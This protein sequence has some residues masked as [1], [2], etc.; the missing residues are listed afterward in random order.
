VSHAPVRVS[1]P[2]PSR[3]DPSPES[4]VNLGG[5]RYETLPASA[6]TEPPEEVDADGARCARHR[7]VLGDPGP[8][9]GCMKAREAAE[10]AAERQRAERLERRRNCQ[11]CG[12]SGFIENA[13]GRPVEK[14]DHRPLLEVVSS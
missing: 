3:P 1:R 7:G 11:R 8:C 2:D 10:Q 12:G 4:L 5:H 9:R 6:D 13:D 14:C